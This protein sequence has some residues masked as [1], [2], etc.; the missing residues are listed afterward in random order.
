[1]SDASSIVGMIALA[2]GL[3]GLANAAIAGQ[4]EL[5]RRDRDANV[6]KPGWLGNVFVG[7]LAAVAIWAVYGPMAMGVMIGPG[8]SAVPVS[9]HFAEFGAALVT[10]VGGGRFLS[11]EVDRRLAEK[12][13]AALEAAKNALAGTVERMTRE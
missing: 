5:P 8:N 6:F 1:L 10:G 3:G 9:L 12:E 11:A 4:L 2:G 7:S 13:K